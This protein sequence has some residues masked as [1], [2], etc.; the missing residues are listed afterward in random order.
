MPDPANIVESKK[1]HWN[2][3]LSYFCKARSKFRWYNDIQFRN[4]KLYFE[5]DKVFF[6]ELIFKLF[7]KAINEFT[8]LESDIV[9]KQI[10]YCKMKMTYIQYLIKLLKEKII[11]SDEED[12]TTTEEEDN[13]N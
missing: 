2:A 6:L 5:E 10:K 13:C 12:M 8:K 3:S 11:N 7:S 1:K 4:K 9:L